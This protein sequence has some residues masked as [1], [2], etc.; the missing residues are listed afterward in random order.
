MNMESTQQMQH[1]T[2]Q[3]HVNYFDCLFGAL[4]FVLNIPERISRAG[5]G[6]RGHCRHTGYGVAVLPRATVGHRRTR[7][8]RLSGSEELLRGKAKG[9]SHGW[10]LQSDSM[11]QGLVFFLLICVCYLLLD[12]P[13]GGQRYLKTWLLSKACT[14]M[15]HI[16][17]AGRKKKKSKFSV[18]FSA[19]EHKRHHLIFFFFF[20]AVLTCMEATSLRVS[21]S[22]GTI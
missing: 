5:F 7:P 4:G 3:M 12:S 18:G 6:R 11:E 16:R 22:R 10:A 9:L 17:D 20:H 8:A 15:L 13:A 1:A 19:A 2:H 21:F 14:H